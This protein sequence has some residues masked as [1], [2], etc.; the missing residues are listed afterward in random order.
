[1]LYSF[2][3]GTDGAN[4]KDSLAVGTNGSLHRT[5]LCGGALKGQRGPR[6]IRFISGGGHGNR[7]PP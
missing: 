6:S 5:T 3:G 1:M 4:S 7:N 2:T